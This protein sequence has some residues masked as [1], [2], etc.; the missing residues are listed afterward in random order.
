PLWIGVM[1]AVN[2]E[3]GS[4][5]PPSGLVLFA[6]KSL[7]PKGFSTRDLFAGALPF[8]GVLGAFMVLIIAFPVLST[9]LPSTM[10]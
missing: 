6:L 2:S 7:L 9:W 4:I 5:C 3:I 10:H 8:V 1:T